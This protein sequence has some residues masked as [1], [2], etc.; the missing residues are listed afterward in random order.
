M[1]IGGPAEELIL[2]VSIVAN[3]GR[4]PVF[5]CDPSRLDFGIVSAE[6]TPEL[7]TVVICKA[8][9]QLV[10]PVLCA[11]PA[12]TEMGTRISVVGETVASENDDYIVTKTILNCALPR[13]KPGGEFHDKLSLLGE[14]A[15]QQFHAA[16]SLTA[17]VEEPYQLS[18]K[19][20]FFD[21]IVLGKMEKQWITLSA[22]PL[23]RAA[24]VGLS[25]TATWISGELVGVEAP[26]HKSLRIEIVATPTKHG[27]SQGALIVQIGEHRMEI[28]V[29]AYAE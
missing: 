5:Y 17:I 26:G 14:A 19:S 28:P 27:I 20:V 22:T 23:P 13:V 8:P 12:V 4:S 25:S 29:V 18:Q 10:V 7:T 15:S 1:L 21:R 11:V 6:S 2:R 9:K 24:D 3:V 16:V